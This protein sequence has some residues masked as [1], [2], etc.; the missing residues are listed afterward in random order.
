MPLSSNKIVKGVNSLRWAHQK[1][2]VPNSTHSIHTFLTHKWIKQS[3][4]IS[5]LFSSLILEHSIKQSI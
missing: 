5:L 4:L 1:Q 2:L 3:E